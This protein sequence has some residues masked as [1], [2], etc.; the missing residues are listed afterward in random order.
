MYQSMGEAINEDPETIKIMVADMKKLH[1]YINATEEELAELAKITLV[2][3]Q[4]AKKLSET[5]SKNEKLLKE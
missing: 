5:I 1:K 4:N 3:N 2:F